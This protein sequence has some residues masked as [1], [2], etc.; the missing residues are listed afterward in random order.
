MELAQ[1][2]AAPR[3]YG[4][5]RGKKQDSHVRR[6]QLLFSGF[7]IIEWRVGHQLPLPARS[8][9]QAIPG[10]LFLARFP[11]ARGIVWANDVL[12]ET[13]A[14]QTPE[15]GAF[16]APAR[17]CFLK[18]SRVRN[19]SARLWRASV[20]FAACLGLLHI[21]ITATPIL[22]YWTAQL[23][24]PWGLSDGDTLIVLG[25]DVISPTT[26]GIS[27]YWR[28]FYATLVWRDAHFR[29][30]IVSGRDAAPLM[31]D[32]LVCHGVPAEAIVVEGTSDSTRE[33]ALRVA[34]L[35]AAD[36]ANRHGPVVLLSSEF[37][38]RRALASFRKAGVQAEPLPWPDASKRIGAYQDRWTIFC[39]LSVETMKTI[40]YRSKG[41]T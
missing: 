31:K 9:N 1:F 24:T 38:L 11:V 40:Y 12:A 36:A 16:L 30:V 15:E 18:M 19:I 4:L 3:R 13:S 21:V 27:S 17:A 23:S 33:N 6:V 14:R 28:T 7:P 34:K 26:L 10:R 32:F 2:C 37:H 41:W 25:S 5:S 39:V 29:R 8:H 35:L 22:G 20:N